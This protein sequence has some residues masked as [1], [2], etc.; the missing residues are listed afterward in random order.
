MPVFQLY[1]RQVGFWASQTW[2]HHVKEFQNKPKI[3]NWKNSA[4]IC[5]NSYM[6]SR[7]GFR[8]A[9]A[10]PSGIRAPADPKGPPLYYFEITI[11]GPLNFSKGALGAN[12]YSFWGGSSRQK[13]ALFW[14]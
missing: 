4:Q 10:S 2:I 12:I 5:K 14:S 9:D 13:N 3:L 1:W 6:Q 8:G 11:D 7:G